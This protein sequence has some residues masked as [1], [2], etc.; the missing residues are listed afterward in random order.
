MAAY[1]SSE[2]VCELNRN[3]IWGYFSKQFFLIIVLNEISFPLYSKYS[4]I[5]F[6]GRHIHFFFF[7]FDAT[8]F[9][10]V[11]HLPVIEVDSGFSCYTT[12]ISLSP[13]VP[14]LFAWHWQRGCIN[15]LLLIVS[16]SCI[17]SLCCRDGSGVSLIAHTRACVCV[18]LCHNRVSEN[19]NLLSYLGIWIC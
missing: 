2:D 7:S 11:Q 4:Q 8:G 14:S 3:S 19:W 12:P 1:L 17:I 16:L 13:S 5:W 6:D 15:R 18:C 9:C 10:L